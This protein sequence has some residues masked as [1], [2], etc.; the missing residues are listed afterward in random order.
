[1]RDV[2]SDGHEKNQKKETADGEKKTKRKE[3]KD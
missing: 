1:M 3:K 2:N